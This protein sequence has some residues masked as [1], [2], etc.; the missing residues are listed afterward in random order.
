MA[1]IE[2]SLDYGAGVKDVLQHLLRTAPHLIISSQPL[3]SHAQH[4]VLGVSG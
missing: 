4:Q 1:R 2:L 3:H